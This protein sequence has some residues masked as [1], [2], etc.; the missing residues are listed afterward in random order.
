MKASVSKLTRI[1]SLVGVSL[2]AALTVG[3]FAL[4]RRSA[5]RE[6]VQ[7]TLQVGMSPRQVESALGMRP[8]ALNV[9]KAYEG[10]PYQ[11]ALNEAPLWTFLIPLEVITVSFDE[12]L[13]LV[14]AS[15]ETVRGL[16]EINGGTIV[17]RRAPR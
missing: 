4:P 10:G 3:Y 16:D 13:R 12:K 8:G 5:L 9:E 1:W 15:Y 2:V 11:S 6:Q 17:L 14:D 7:A